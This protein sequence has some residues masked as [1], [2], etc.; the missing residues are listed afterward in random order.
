[1]KGKFY[2]HD[3]DARPGFLWI[4]NPERRV[5]LGSGLH[6]E[7]AFS[8]LLGTIENLP[9]SEVDKLYTEVAWADLTPEAQIEFDYQQ[10]CLVLEE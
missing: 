2:R 1:M 6:Y 9:E 8:S 3:Y 5:I 4:P 7:L 10:S